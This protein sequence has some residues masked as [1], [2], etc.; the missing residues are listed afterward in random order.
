MEFFG[1]ATR[2]KS[3]QGEVKVE[4]RTLGKLDRDELTKARFKDRC[5]TLASARW[6]M[7]IS[8]LSMLQ[9]EVHER[10]AYTFN[11]LLS[12]FIA[13]I[14]RDTSQRSKHFLVSSHSFDMGNMLG[15]M[16]MLLIPCDPT[17][18]HSI[19]PSGPERANE[20]SRDD[21]TGRTADAVP[22]CRYC[23]QQLFV[24]PATQVLAFEDEY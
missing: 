3:A 11:L 20:I 15:R 10:S 16:T 6:D 5:M 13:F 24:T 1:S 8:R 17:D 7:I 19:Y 12:I 18:K 2:S 23:P 22:S 4:A 21:A 14:S 9:E